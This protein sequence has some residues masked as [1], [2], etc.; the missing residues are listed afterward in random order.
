MTRARRQLVV[1]GD[2]RT[3]LSTG[4][5]V[6]RSSALKR[7]FLTKWIGWL[8]DKSNKKSSKKYLNSQQDIELLR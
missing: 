7:E 2:T 8:E 3:L 6:T 4:P 1:I 5:R